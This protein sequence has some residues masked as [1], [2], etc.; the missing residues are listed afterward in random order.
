VCVS[1]YIVVC[2]CAFVCLW[3]SECVFCVCV[4]VQGTA[5]TVCADVRCVLRYMI[6]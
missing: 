2:V 5:E 1:V 4:F 6:G 3:G